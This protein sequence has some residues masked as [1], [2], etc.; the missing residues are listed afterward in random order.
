MLNSY[1]LGFLLIILTI[2]KS[3]NTSE[4]FINRKINHF[5]VDNGGVDHIL[6]G[7]IKI[8]K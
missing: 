8:L 6:F 1:D 2:H 7:L 4:G 5:K 3:K